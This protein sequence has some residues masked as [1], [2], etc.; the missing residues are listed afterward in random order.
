M[1]TTTASGRS[2]TCA[3]SCGVAVRE[4]HVLS[5]AIDI[6]I[7][8]VQGEID[9]MTLPLLDTAVRKLLAAIPATT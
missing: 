5:S 2:S 4:Q 3:E 9:L 8:T 7:L 1:N 6:C